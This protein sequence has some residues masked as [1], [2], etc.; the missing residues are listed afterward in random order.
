MIDLKNMDQQV[1]IYDLQ[2]K[3]DAK[4]GESEKEE[5]E[6]GMFKETKDMGTMME[7]NRRLLVSQDW[8]F[9][10]LYRQLLRKFY[11]N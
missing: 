8:F 11:A 4:V 5:S 1:D 9:S 7:P 3:R 6:Q 2:N 10:I